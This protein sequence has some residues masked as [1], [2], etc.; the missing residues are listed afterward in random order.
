MGYAQAAGL[1]AYAGLYA[2][3]VPLLV[4]AVVGPSRIL[5]LGPDS[6][7][8]PLIA[9]AILPLAVTDDPAS[10]LALAGVLGVLVGV[11]LLAGGYLRLVFAEMKGPIKDRLIRYGLGSRFDSTRFYYT[12]EAAVDSFSHRHDAQ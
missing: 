4:Y 6:S 11:L 5:V 3:I 2:T 9:A 12:L 7:L 8:A 1:P 10:A